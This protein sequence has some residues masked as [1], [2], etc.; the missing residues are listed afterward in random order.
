VADF[1]PLENGTSRGDKLLFKAK[2]KLIYLLQKYLQQL[3][4]RSKHFFKMKDEQMTHLRLLMLPRKLKIMLI[5]S[6]MSLFEAKSNENMLPKQLWQAN[7]QTF[8]EIVYC[9]VWLKDVKINI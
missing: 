9:F 2:F 3:S 5:S 6:K 4:Q 7:L 1:I 8:F